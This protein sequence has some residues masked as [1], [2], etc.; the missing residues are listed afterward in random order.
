MKIIFKTKDE[1]KL[2]YSTWAYDLNY[3]SVMLDF[4]FI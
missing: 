2:D 1:N 4:F 3:D